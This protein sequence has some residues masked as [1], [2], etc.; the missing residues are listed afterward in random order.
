[1]TQVLK[2]STG[3]LTAVPKSMLTLALIPVIMDNL[4]FRHKKNTHQEE[5]I[6]DIKQQNI[7]FTGRISDKIAKGLGK[8]LDNK[9]FQNFAKKI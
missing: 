8:I 7:N 9:S 6:S 2:L 5:K 4:F 3:F 1:M